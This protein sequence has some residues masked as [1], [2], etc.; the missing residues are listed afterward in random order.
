MSRAL[1]YGGK[2][3]KWAE[4]NQLTCKPCVV[5]AKHRDKVILKRE[6]D[7][8]YEIASRLPSFLKERADAAAADR[9]SRASST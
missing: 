6:A 8:S 4:K 1:A 2:W 9:A 3:R 5:P 7:G